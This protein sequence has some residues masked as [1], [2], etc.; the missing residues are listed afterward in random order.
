MR[1]MP[2]PGAAPAPAFKKAAAA[3]RVHGMA[4][5]EVVEEFPWGHPTL[6]VKGKAFIFMGGAED[7]QGFS[8]TVKLTDSHGAALMM[9][10]AQPAGYGLGK[11]GWVTCTFKKG[12]RAPVELL[13]VW[14]TESYRAVAPK[15]LAAQLD[16][17]APA[18][19]RKAAVRRPT[20]K[21]T[22]AKKAA[23]TKRTSA[24]RR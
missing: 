6:K 19:A 24:A 4:F 2:E 1:P 22:A 23:A 16:R 12:D 18:P 11:S 9:P 17:G 14:T 5:P 7:G 3:L 20:A 8:V 15:K 10:F 21:K 13:Q